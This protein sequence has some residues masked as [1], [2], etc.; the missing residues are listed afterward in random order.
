ML[1]PTTGSSLFPPRGGPPT[2]GT[3]VRELLPERR[4][5]PL[6]E[7]HE[8]LTLDAGTER[9]WLALGMVSS[10]DGAAAVG[11][12][13]GDL[14]GDGDH[15][16]F[17]RLRGAADA[18]LV[19]AGTVRDENYGPPR[20]TEERRADRERRGLAPRPR[21]VILSRRL[22]LAPDHRVFADQ[23]HP[24]LIVTTREHDQR[25]ASA[26][27]EVAEL[28]TV[29]EEEVDLPRL[30][31]RLA[32]VGLRR[33]LCEGGPGVN[34]ALLE[35]DLVDEVF[36]TV[37]PTAHAGEAPRIARSGSEPPPRRFALT[38]LHEHDGELL[39]RYRRAR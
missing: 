7:V 8:G 4:D 13:S 17:R 20:G 9:A 2:T 34:G 1:P 27:A 25:R 22:D 14:G 10:L 26:L 16:A 29:G 18:I 12:T 21:L 35:L 33:V 6:D 31:I 30:L 37:A 28:W 3:V 11:G 23:E 19:G 38:S 5:L 32:E 24:P 39:L 36:L 15:Q